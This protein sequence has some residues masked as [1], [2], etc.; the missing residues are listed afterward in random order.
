LGIKL[1][2]AF[3]DGFGTVVLPDAK[4]ASAAVANTLLGRL[5]AIEVKVLATRLTH[6]SGSNAGYCLFLRQIEVEDL[7]HG[8]M[9]AEMF[10]LGFCARETVEHDA[11]GIC[12]DGVGN[13]AK[14]QLVFHKLASGDHSFDLVAKLS[15][16]GHLV[17]QQIANID[18]LVAQ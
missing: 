12:L 1:D 11:F 10:S 2:H 9:P 6:S 18:V 8:E 17:S 4:F 14:D 5:F 16:T 7:A 3:T 15:S 13:E